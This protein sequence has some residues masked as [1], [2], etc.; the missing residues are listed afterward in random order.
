MLVCWEWLNEY[1]EITE[2]PEDMALK[3][4]MSGLNHEETQQVGSDTVIDLEVTSN[5]GDCL[6]HIGVAREA[7]V[8]LRQP[9]KLP[10]PSPAENTSAASAS[11]EVDNQFTEGCPEYTARII[12][13]VKIGPSPDWLVRRLKSVGIE[14]VSNVVDITNYVLMECGQ[15]L[16]AFDLSQIRGNKIIVRAA[17]EK[18][19]FEAIDHKTYELDSQMV[20]IADAERAVALGGVMGG[21]DSEISESTTDLLIEAARFTP[22]AVRRAARKLK[23]H[24]PS[25]YRFERTPDPA[26]LDWASSRCCQLILELCGGELEQGVVSDG[27]KAEAPEEITFRLNQVERVLG[28][29]IPMEDNKRILT[30]LGCAVSD[31]GEGVLSVTPPSWRTD[32]TREC[33]LLEEV[34][35]MYGYEEIPENVAVPIGVAAPRPK[36]VTMGRARLSLSAFGIDEAMT[37]S[38]V[39]NGQEKLGSL[40]STGEP[41]SV[42]TPLLKGAKSLRRSVFPSLLDA[43]YFNQTQSIRNAELFEVATIYLPGKDG[44][45]PSEKS[46]L[47][48][49]TEGDL[50]RIKGVVESILQEV[51]AIACTWEGLEHDLLEAGTGQK[52]SI[53]GKVLGYL[54]LVSKSAQNYFS[55]DAAVAAAEL[56]VML[57]TELLQPV[58]RANQVSAFPAMERDLN[59]VVDEGVRWASLEELCQQH[60]GEIL[61]T[62]DYRETYRDAKKD[63]KGKKRLL[64][65][66][67]FRS[68]ERTLTGEEVDKSV[69]AIVSS[70]GN[71]L[72]A[73][74]LA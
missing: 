10:E 25:S 55:L 47:G 39:K 68:L 28:I 32:L 73:K 3:F 46:M 2:T 45:L 72:E 14:P 18:E 13:G 15:P 23:L 37:P 30:D 35:R 4:A 27:A 71:S 19:Q 58:R 65:T 53:D 48:I 69:Q 62:V 44:E 20:V 60:G 66:L 33:D 24:S 40:W 49:V 22:L 36:D 16:H 31:S 29:E 50:Q 64:L 43:R 17:E 54:G 70:A 11:I 56:D 52:L 12:R 61:E 57:L 26:G 1:V 42:D 38:V 7:S 8:L 63:G 59:F 67:V 6:G 41:L 51:G 34:A 5:R 74:L 21:V 9:L